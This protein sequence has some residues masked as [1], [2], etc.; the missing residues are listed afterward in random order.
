M[1]KPKDLLEHLETGN[2]TMHYLKKKPEPQGIT[3]GGLS[4][5]FQQTYGTT[6]RHWSNQLAQQNATWQ[7][8]QFQG[9]TNQW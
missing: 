6:F 8:S 2:R 4:N 5:M 7:T 1:T 9:R 3:L